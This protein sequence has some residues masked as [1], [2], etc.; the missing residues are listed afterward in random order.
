MNGMAGYWGRMRNSRRKRMS[1]MAAGCEGG[2]RRRGSRR[3]RGSANECERGGGR[4]ERGARSSPIV[5]EGRN[6]AD[7]P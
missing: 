4:S 3:E 2:A 6:S 1:S 7:R 5:A